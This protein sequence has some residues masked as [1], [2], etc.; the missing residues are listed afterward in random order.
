MKRR[1]RQVDVARLAG[2]SPAVVSQVLNNR[3]QSSVRIG[4]ETRQRVVAA[5]EKLGYVPD[6]A[7]QSLARGENHLLGVFTYQAI[8]PIQNQ[9]FY[10]PFL[11]GIEE[12]AEQAGYDLLLFT[13]AIGGPDRQRKIYRNGAN[14][15]RLAD[16]AVLLGLEEDKEDLVRL[17]Q[18]GYPFVFVGRREA[19]G[20]EITC[21]AADYAAATAQIVA[22]LLAMGHRRI[23]YWGC[24]LINESSRDRYAGYRQVHTDAGL[25]VDDRL[26]GQG[27]AERLTPAWLQHILDLGATALVAQHD[28]HALACLQAAQALGKRIPEDL[29]LAMLGDPVGLS[30]PKGITTFEIPQREMGAQAVKLLMLQFAEP[31]SGPLQATLSCRFVPGRT[32]APPGSLPH[33]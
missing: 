17:V 30:V 23:A 11:I 18:E 31:T 22:Y 13:S 28:D 5:I 27:A 10:Y 12:A 24:G 3:A 4:A 32:V 2:V 14:R 8:F 15:L 19:P 33:V 26:H 9:D 20:V 1:P 6:P 21:V 7:A 16:G 29:S 25:S